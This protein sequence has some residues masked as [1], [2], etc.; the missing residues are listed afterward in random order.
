MRHIWLLFLLLPVAYAVEVSNPV[1]RIASLDTFHCEPVYK[2]NACLVKA[3]FVVESNANLANPVVSVVFRDSEGRDKGKAVSE[4]AKQLRYAQGIGGLVRN[5]PKRIDFEFWTE[6]SGKYDVTVN[7]LTLDPYYNITINAS[8]PSLWLKRGMVNSTPDTAFGQVDIT[9][10]LSDGDLADRYATYRYSS[11]GSSGNMS[12]RH[13]DKD[14]NNI[15]ATTRYRDGTVTAEINLDG[16]SR[17]NRLNVTDGYFTNGT[18]VTLYMT[19]NDGAS[20]GKRIAL[21]EGAKKAAEFALLGPSGSYYQ[22]QL[23]LDN[24]TGTG[25]M[26]LMYDASDGAT[27]VRFDSIHVGQ[28]TIARNYSDGHAIRA[29]YNHSYNGSLRYWLKLY[30]TDLGIV[31][32]YA[33]SYRNTTHLNMSVNQSI[34]SGWDVLRIDGIVP[35]GYNRAW[36]VYGQGVNIS[37]MQLI[38]EAY[39]DG[40][41]TIANCTVND[42][43]AGCGDTVRYACVITDDTV[44][45]EARYAITENASAVPH[46]SDRLTPLS[47]IFIVDRTMPSYHGSY[48]YAFTLVNAS[49]HLGQT[50]IYQPNLTG[51]WSC[52][53]ERWTATEQNYTACLTNDSYYSVRI[54][55][56]E[57]ACNTTYSL[58]VDNGT[59]TA[60]PCDYCQPNISLVYGPCLL[61]QRNVS[62]TDSN[63][64]SCCAVTNLSSDCPALTSYTFSCGLECY[65]SPEP[66]LK[67]GFLLDRD[68]VDYY[69]ITSNSTACTN[70][71]TT[72][73]GT[74]L[75]TNPDRE[76]VAESGE[77]AHF[78]AEYGIMRGYYRKGDLLPGER[79]IVHTSCGG[80]EGDLI[81]EP[82]YKS[83]GYSLSWLSYAKDNIGIAIGSLIMLVLLLTVIY[84]WRKA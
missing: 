55:T 57:H 58:P 19:S 26:L 18:V 66:F 52:C 16:L 81:I 7:G 78:S 22:Y 8:Y 6:T 59:L 46:L 61:G 9:Y 40:A 35:D 60:H 72:M 68:R 77:E 25:R 5:T 21:F 44:V 54:Y 53:I 49:D 17:A 82:R 24:L 64:M 2:G 48:S 41:P 65:A 47:D 63:A 83:L 1:L 70:T 20:V 15:T 62:E 37:E 34:H 80:S 4:A 23:T 76:L 43:T 79:F 39:D 14:G 84:L 36:R 33:H 31:N 42:T 30:K 45:D 38:E 51:A 71:V 3:H 50:S 11:Y 56:D 13:F 29:Y 27:K 12:M 69:C 10:N 73:D 67:D 28:S 75:Q 32:A 74:L